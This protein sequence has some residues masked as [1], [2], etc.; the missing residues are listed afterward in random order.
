MMAKIFISGLPGIHAMCKV[1]FLSHALS[2]FQ[3]TPCLANSPSSQ[4]CTNPNPVLTGIWLV[5]SS[6]F[7]C[8]D[9]H[10]L[11]SLATFPE[12]IGRSE[13]RI[14]LFVEDSIG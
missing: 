6:A 2:L 5:P 12:T 3:F 9:V 10:H 7:L 13:N 11:T 1:R 4:V 8:L 14:I